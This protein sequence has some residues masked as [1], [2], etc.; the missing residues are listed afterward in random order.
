MAENL[1]IFDFTLDGDDVAAISALDR[2]QRVG[3]D[4]ETFDRV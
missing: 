4:P 1:D 3:P 2:G